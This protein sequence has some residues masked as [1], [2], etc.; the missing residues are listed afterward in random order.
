MKI[1]IFLLFCSFIIFINTLNCDENQNPSSLSD[2]ENL[3]VS[4]GNKCCY[5]Y[6][7]VDL[8]GQSNGF[9]GCEE[10]TKEQYENKDKTIKEFKE[11]IKKR[12]NKR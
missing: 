9:P 4:D 8:D 5:Y 12:R 1:F 11:E 6:I 3:S 10:F 2:C 7:V